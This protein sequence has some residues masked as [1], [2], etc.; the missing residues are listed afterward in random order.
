MNYDQI[1]FLVIMSVAI[2]LFIS[3]YL[4]V[5]VVAV[6]IILA[7]SMTGLISAQEAFSGL[8]S[9]PAI[10][11]VAVFVLSAG[12]ALS[13]VTNWI[14]RAVALLAG[15][16]ESV[17]I[18]VI[19][20]AVAI[21]SAFTHHLMV[22]AMMLPIV[23]KICKDNGLHSSRLLIPMATAASLG[24]TM[25]L[26]GAPAFL[27]AN[28][29]LI[30]AGQPALHIFSIT[31][32]G[33][34]LVA[35]G[36]VICLILKWLLP[37]R[38]GKDSSDDRFKL[39]DV[40]TDILV[41]QDSKWIGLK[42]SQLE[43]E[44]KERF[45]ILSWI[46]ANR[47][48][49][50]QNL[51]L[52]IEAGDIFLAKM[53]ADE[54][55]SI[56]EK[57]GLTLRAVKRYG[58]KL[59]DDLTNFAEEE[60]HILKAVVAP[61]SEFIG[62]TLGQVHFFHRFG[63]VAIGI[64]RKEGWISQTLAKVVLREGDLVVVWGPEKYLEALSSHKGFLLFLP[65][66]GRATKR[67]KTTTAVA[68]MLASVLAAA[69]GLLPAYVAFVAGAMAMILSGCVSVEQAYESVEAKIFV[70]IAGVIPLGIAMEKVGIDKVVAEFIVHYTVGWS[71]LAMMLILFWISALLTQIL[72][73]AATTVLLAPI[74]LAFAIDVGISPTAAVI[75]ITIGAVASFLTPIGHHGNLLILTPGGYKF[76]DFL[77][78]GLPL[79]AVLSVIT[80][81]LSLMFWTV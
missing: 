17:A 33:L 53:D 19:M 16:R 31:K 74:G 39:S 34:C 7:L 20:V 35:A 10:I 36:I 41:P 63:V 4:R 1:L 15:K 24:T 13:G 26:I 72:S 29:I 23:M 47:P 61:H 32:L 68:I 67:I 9:E 54:L 66:K 60:K 49:S 50:I 21:M 46:R 76:L 2:F 81:V 51:D 56:D 42:F 64:W 18:L 52:P 78:I 40:T 12:L 3:E 11:V 57:Q 44:T 73:D 8:S 5:D 43:D 14:G 28:S 70:M 45:E 30:R 62:K 25:T 59:A 55:V 65:F 80:C 22:T 69:T 75:C 48:V 6:L 71:P 27:L 38:S 79:T 37:L 77:K 58:W